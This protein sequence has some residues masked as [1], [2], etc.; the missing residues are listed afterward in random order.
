MEYCS[1]AIKYIFKYSDHC[2]CYEYDTQNVLE[3]TI[4]KI[5]I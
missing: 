5:V 1:R 2:I 3:T 4:Q